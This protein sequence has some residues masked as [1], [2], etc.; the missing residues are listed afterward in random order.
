MFQS[1]RTYRVLLKNTRKFSN[2]KFDFH[3]HVHQNPSPK[4]YD[5]D[6]F[7]FDNDKRFACTESFP[8][9]KPEAV[10]YIQ[11][12]C[13]DE[14]FLKKTKYV[15]DFA[16]FTIRAP[17]LFN[18][19]MWKLYNC[20]LFAKYFSDIVGEELV[21]HTDP[22]Q[23]CH[24]NVTEAV[25]TGKSAFDWH[26]DPQPITILFNVS[27]FEE[28]DDIKGGSTF[29]RNHKTGEALE[30]QKIINTNFLKHS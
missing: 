7:G 6:Y 16:P 1:I 28:G 15:T 22:Y 21:W 2:L 9:L 4:I 24:V 17:G 26:V 18:D 29:I 20:D 3:K 14:E 13:E 10:D 19:F 30:L 8:V 12:L 5:L 27:H 23:A 25:G 11:R